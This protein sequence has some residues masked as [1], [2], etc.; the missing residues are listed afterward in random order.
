MADRVI[1]V[2][3]IVV[4]AVYFY[5]TTL[6]PTLEIGDPLGPKAFPRL[7][8][9]CLLVAAGLLFLEM[10]KDRA[11]AASPKP[12]A[13]RQD[14]RHLRVLAAVSVWTLAYYLAFEN[15]GYIVA[16]SIYLLALMA[17]FNRARWIA[18]VASAVL[19]SIFSYVM[20]L[21]LDVRLP[22]GILPY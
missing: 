17:W 12:A 16:T 5:A 6:I 22:P 4:A 14:L 9:V 2:C 3:T 8:G 13:A 20:F 11:A 15:V 10:W 7:L 21:K 18:N 1:F 19:F